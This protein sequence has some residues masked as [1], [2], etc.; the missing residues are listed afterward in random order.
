VIRAYIHEGYAFAPDTLAVSLV[1]EFNEP[2]FHQRLI[3][4]LHA[5]DD[6]RV[7]RSWDEFETGS[8]EPVEPT[9]TLG[10]EEAHVLANA[11]IGYFGGVD[12]Q[13]ALRRDY[14]HERE[15]R[16]K[17]TAAVIEIATARGRAA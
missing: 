15:Q 3:M 16:D 11:L 4:H 5:G 12:D 13:R 7:S 1:N 17:L 8:L 2:G 10:R 6:G 9:L 14:E